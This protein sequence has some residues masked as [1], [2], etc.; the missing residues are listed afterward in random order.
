MDIKRLK[1]HNGIKF[2]FNARFEMH[3]KLLDEVIEKDKEW[4]R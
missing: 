3:R 2:Y 4:W 1:E